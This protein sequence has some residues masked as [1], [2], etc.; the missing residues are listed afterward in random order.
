MSLIGALGSGL[1]G[2]LAHQ[3]AVETTGNNIAN[4]NTPGYSRQTVKLSPNSAVEIRG[5]LIGQGV[6]VQE[7]SREY[8]GFISSRLV[9]QSDVMGR[10]GAKSAPLAQ[11]ERVFGAGENSLASD[12]ESF[13]GAWH[14]LSLN[15]GGNAERDRVLYEGNNLLDSFEQTGGELVRIRQDIDIDLDAKVDEINLKIQEIADLNESVTS[16]ESLGSMASS[17]RDRR[18]I[19][20]QELS[21][22]IGVRTY[23][24]GDGKI[25]V[26]LHG[27]IPLVQE[28]DAMVFE[29]YRSGDSLSFRVKM[30]GSVVPLNRTNFGGEFGGSL[31]V[32]D[33]FIPELQQDLSRLKNELITQVNDRHE[34]GYGLD[35]QTGRP[36]FSDAGGGV[37]AVGL[38][39][40]REIAAAEGP[41]GAPG[42]N[43]NAMNMYGL[44]NAG[45]FDGN[46]TFTEFAAKI[47]S[48]VGIESKQN[49]MALGGAKDTFTQ[50]E[51]MRE[52]AV[53]VSIEEEMIN[54][55]M[56]QMGFD[57]C[58]T[59]VRTVDEMMTTVLDLKR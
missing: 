52:A 30:G 54:L 6:K 9:S 4:V 39:S 10:E 28:N 26:Q 1:S 32:R 19:L 43:L 8:E 34:A 3:K 46:E 47:V 38:S 53:G 16:K 13:F 49:A 12:I 55:T 22:M 11:L 35:G 37:F 27:G 21:E 36:F 51:N 42:D 15:P 56:Y 29:S 25:N 23:P 48:K 14:D 5:R 45:V 40:A 18:D 57:A 17:D 20:I 2:I 7:I 44:F 33:E 58:A 41:E 59:F 24:S 31:D 50:L